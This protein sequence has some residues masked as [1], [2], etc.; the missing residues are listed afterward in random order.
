MHN[1]NIILNIYDIFLKKI[2]FYSFKFLNFLYIFILFPST[3][4]YHN[5]NCDYSLKYDFYQNTLY[6]RKNI[7]SSVIKNNLN[8]A[9]IIKIIHLLTSKI[10]KKSIL[11]NDH[12]STIN[13]TMRSF[14]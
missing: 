11:H 12:S 1:F 13:K 2:K 10:C 6:F 4:D 3:L 14:S 5:Q 8:N 7:I 9:C